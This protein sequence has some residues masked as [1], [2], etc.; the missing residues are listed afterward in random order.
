[1]ESRG[2]D[3]YEEGSMNTFAKT[4]KSPV[5]RGLCL[6]GNDAVKR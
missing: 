1:M 3:K 5:L 6:S 2:K 4:E